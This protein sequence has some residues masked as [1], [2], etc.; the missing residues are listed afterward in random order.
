[1]HPLIETLSGGL[2]LPDDPALAVL[3]L[4]QSHDLPAT[5]SHCAAVAEECRRL[6]LRFG[7]DPRAAELAGWLHDVSAVW[8]SSQ[9]LEVALG[10]GLDVLPAERRR[11]MLLHQRLS[12]V[13][14]EQLFAVRDPAILAAIACHTTLRPSPTRL[15]LLLFVADK[16]AWDQPGAPPYWAAMQAALNESLAAAAQVYL[17]HLWQQRDSLAALHPWLVDAWKFY[18]IAA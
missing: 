10:L 12:A 13:L 9:R 5:A 2:R 3:L 4:L 16:L 1:M 15:D 7:A 11:P 8:P 17:R 18:N 14:A 6:A